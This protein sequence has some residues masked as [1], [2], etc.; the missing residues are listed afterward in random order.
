[1]G[2]RRDPMSAAAEAI[3][4]IEQICKHSGQDTELPMGGDGGALLCTVGEISAWPGASNVIP[5]EVR[6]LDD[7]L[8]FG[9]ILFAFAARISGFWP[10]RALGSSWKTVP[11]L[12]PRCLS[13]YGPQVGFTVDIRAENDDL[14][15]EATDTIRKRIEEASENR[16][17]AFDIAVKVHFISP[18]LAPENLLI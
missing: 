14:R 1:M 9:E 3:V 17:V 7:T 4:G 13:D 15:A 10:V 12:V 18:F 2:M 16:R 5:A 8:D 11:D 6:P